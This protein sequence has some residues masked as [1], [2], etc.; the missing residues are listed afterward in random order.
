VAFF[1]GVDIDKCIRKEYNI[2]FVTP[3]NRN[4][5]SKGYGIPLGECLDIHQIIEKTNG[6]L[7]KKKKV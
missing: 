3:S 5:L 7:E 6:S 4:G 2:N 1:S